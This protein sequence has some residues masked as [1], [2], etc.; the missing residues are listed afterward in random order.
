MPTPAKPI[1]LNAKFTPD[2]WQAEAITA[3]MRRVV[4][5]NGYRRGIVNVF[6]GGGKTYAAVACLIHASAE[7]PR[8]KLAVVAPGVELA[9]QW[10]TALGWITDVPA[11]RVGRVG[12][13]VNFNDSFLTHD[14]L[15]FTLETAR[16]GALERAC[17]GQK[18]MLLCDECHAMGAE[19]S[20]AI[21]RAKV[22]HRI[23]ISATPDRSGPDVQDD[24]GR[25]RPL[26][27]QIQCVEL[28]AEFFRLSLADGR[29]R[30][31]LPAYTVNH[32]AVAL[33]PDE[34]D[35]YEH[36]CEFCDGIRKQLAR[37]GVNPNAYGV[38]ARSKEGRW[39]AAVVDLAQKLQA[40]YL[41][42]KQCLYTSSERHR[43]AVQLVVQDLH[44]S[45]CVLIMQERTGRDGQTAAAD[46]GAEAIHRGLLRAIERGELPLGT[47]KVGIVHSKL[48]RAA[49]AAT[50]RAFRAGQLRILVS[51]KSLQ[52]GIDLPELDTLI[53]VSSNSQRRTRIQSVG[54]VL[55]PG[56]DQD[57]S[58]LPPH[59]RRAKTVHHLFVRGTSD[60]R[61]Y[62][63][64]DWVEEL[65]EEQTRWWD[66]RVGAT[67]PVVGAAIR[68]GTG[69]SAADDGAGAPDG[70]PPAPAI[71]AGRHEPPRLRLV[72]GGQ[73][74]LAR[75]QAGPPDWGRAE[76][77]L[78]R[79]GREHAEEWVQILRG[80][81]PA[82]RAPTVAA[83]RMFYTEAVEEALGAFL[84]GD[85]ERVREVRDYLL[86]RIDRARDRGAVGKEGRLEA[87]LEALE[88]LLIG[89]D[90][91]AGIA[92]R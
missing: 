55:R 50:M 80:R 74:P 6:T 14:I 36:L 61:V 73:P 47:E 69:Q 46:F 35:Q 25:V 23:G 52:Q 90:P 3:Y 24:D 39:P 70:H 88:A 82:R 51:A 1:Q 78:R 60:D 65:G 67:R 79:G 26:S 92:V 17:R 9:G 57:G 62:K 10:V 12:G 53:T 22:T 32:Q 43:V 72:I 5:G 71:T 29:R 83:R 2:P 81:Q 38:I 16:T 64:H 34:S 45:R 15:V 28:G 31:L 13:G 59:L 37:R 84:A 42:R 44:K 20:Q 48:S 77:C 11:E 66:W 68:P 18:V 63:E 41:Q 33:S 85:R 27:E 76:G 49:N 75:N 89:A 58:L 56:R 7:G 4:D 86:A 8:M 54:R 30:G 87:L 91:R 40:L 21:F 19:V